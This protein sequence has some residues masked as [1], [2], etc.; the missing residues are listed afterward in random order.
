MAADRWEVLRDLLLDRGFT[1]TTLTN[2]E[3]TKFQ[4][5][6]R[7]FIYEESSFQPNRFDMLGFG[8]SGINFTAGKGLR[9]AVKTLNPD[10][11]AD[12][13]AAVQSGG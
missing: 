11:S 9:R 1:Q 7:R 3:R 4:C 10:S 13:L 8:P 2:F 5:D 6:A 12:Y